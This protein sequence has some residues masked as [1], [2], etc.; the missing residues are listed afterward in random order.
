MVTGLSRSQTSTAQSCP[1]VDPWSYGPQRLK[2]CGFFDYHSTT[3]G[4]LDYK[5][6]ETW[7]EEWAYNHHPNQL[8][9]RPRIIA[10]ID[11]DIHQNLRPI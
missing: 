11:A 8:I 1:T 10:L 3:F 4:Y 7:K 9:E 6:T 5:I 2:S